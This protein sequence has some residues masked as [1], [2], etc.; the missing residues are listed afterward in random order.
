MEEKKYN[1]ITVLI[2]CYNEEAAIKQVVD[3]VEAAMRT[4]AYQYEILLVDDNSTDKTVEIINEIKPLNSKIS[5]KRLAKLGDNPEEANL[6]SP[7]ILF[8]KDWQNVNFKVIEIRYQDVLAY[9]LS[10]GF[11]KMKFAP[12]FLAPAILQLDK[13]LSKFGW[14]NKFFGFKMIIVLEKI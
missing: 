3:D 14:L 6:A 4:T 9:P 10:G 2:P 12:N 5:F 7:T 8:K 1:F 11:S 13:C